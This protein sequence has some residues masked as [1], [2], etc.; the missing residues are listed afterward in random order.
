MT[1]RI[2]IFALLWSIIL[3]GHSV[4]NLPDCFAQTKDQPEAKPGQPAAPQ[5]PQAKLMKVGEI[6]IGMA[7]YGLTV[8]Q[9]DK[10]IE[11]FGITVMGVL[12]NGNGPKYDMILIKC[13]HP[14]VDKAGVIAGMSGSPIYIVTDK[15]KEPAGRLI[16]ALGYGWSFT[17]ESVAGVT[18]IELMLADLNK[19]I[20]KST[21]SIK[22]SDT[23]YRLA[24][25]PSNIKMAEAPGA[26]RPLMT[27]LFVSGISTYRLKYLA[28]ALERYNIMPVQSGG[29]TGAIKETVSQEL[30][31]GS[32]IGVRLVGGDEDWVGVGTVTYVDGD[33][34]LAFG[35]RMEMWGEEIQAPMTNA[36]IYG[37]MSSINHSFKF[38]S[39][40]DNI[41]VLQQDRR[42]SISG[43]L[44][45]TAPMIPM[46]I[47]VENTKTGRKETFN[48]EVL[49]AYTQF[50]ET[51]PWLMMSAA[52]ATELTPFEPA[53]IEV[54]T[55]LKIKD[56]EPMVFKRLVSDSV[57]GA[58]CGA[59]NNI[60]KPIW[61][62]PYLKVPVE[63]VAFDM[64]IT[65]ENRALQLLN[66]WTEAKEVLPGE[67]IRIY[68]QLKPY[69]KEPFI[70][71]IDFTV[72]SDLKPPQTLAVTIMSSNNLMPPLPSPTNVPELI[73]YLK[74]FYDGGNLVALMSLPG[75]DL[76]FKGNNYKN[77]PGSFLS[78]LINQWPGT[79]YGA[80][81][82]D[83]YRRSP[84]FEKPLELGQDYVMAIEPMQNIVYG[85]RSVAV[86]LVK[87]KSK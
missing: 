13:S 23:E 60:F 76:K 19:P 34:I 21:G 40:I 33:K 49:A 54:T 16:G 58:G 7:G 12:K 6:K 11:K 18:P 44:K 8:F 39:G 79:V 5:K 67:T 29:A 81:G 63:N 32:A 84:T 48:Y 50:A 56:Q 51:I 43:T 46:K 70:K 83:T 38:G 14:V 9:S 55:T 74:S 87:Y 1:K 35:H 4:G 27:P 22:D 80:S 15:D 86:N 25:L 37:T 75:I 78:G 26:M 72:P 47:S 62:N 36:Y 82:Y 10:G 68:C 45:K 57:S 24:S 17:N 64:R 41:G 52:D 2:I 85:S 61:Y 71:T 53:M 42:S 59:I 65:N 20:E 73:S 66:A 3:L 30:E 77:L 69:L 28:K 31:P